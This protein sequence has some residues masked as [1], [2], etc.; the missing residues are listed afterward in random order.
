[1]TDEDPMARLKNRLHGAA[2]ELRRVLDAVPPTG[3]VAETENP[4]AARAKNAALSTL[5]KSNANFAAFVDNKARGMRPERP[6]TAVV[7]D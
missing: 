4:A 1:M 7:P 3:D 6:E 2:D 5:F